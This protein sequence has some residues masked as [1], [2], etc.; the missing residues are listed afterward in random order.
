MF[1]ICFNSSS[2][3]NGICINPFPVISFLIFTFVF[4]FF[5]NA[6]WA[7]R[8]SSE[9]VI[10]TFDFLLRE[11]SKAAFTKDSVCLTESWRQRACPLQRCG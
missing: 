2:E 3:A 1:R 7:L 10:L 11:P 5:P 4:N 8:T 9:R 6:V